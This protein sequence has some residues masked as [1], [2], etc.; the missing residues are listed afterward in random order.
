MVVDDDGRGSGPEFRQGRALGWT[1]GGPGAKER[2]RRGPLRCR[3]GCE[4]IGVPNANEAMGSPAA[5]W[6]VPGCLGHLRRGHRPV[7][8]EG[9]L[10]G[11]PLSDLFGRAVDEVPVYGSGGFTTYEAATVRQV[12]GWVG[13][14]GHSPGQDQGR[15]VVGQ[16][17]PRDLDRLE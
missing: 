9:R 14:Q 2:G 8:S 5:I 15:R 4:V 6:A 3:D 7:G 16:G 11:L 12:E 1:N 17:G 10:L 13:D